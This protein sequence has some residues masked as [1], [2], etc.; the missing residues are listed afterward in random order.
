MVDKN[1]IIIGGIAVVSV[2]MNF[3]FHLYLFDK[4]EYLI[5]RSAEKHV[6]AE[7]AYRDY[8]ECKT[9]GYRDDRCNHFK[10]L[11]VEKMGEYEQIQSQLDAEIIRNRKAE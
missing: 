7:F 6:E 10:A 5:R 4:P 9:I 3:D 8:K 11:Y 2:A 1:W